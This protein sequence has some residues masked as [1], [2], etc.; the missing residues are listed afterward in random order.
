MNNPCLKRQELVQ[1]WEVRVWRVEGSTRGLIVIIS[2]FRSC[3]LFAFSQ[4]RRDG[5]LFFFIPLREPLRRQ[6]LRHQPGSIRS[7]NSSF[8]SAS[9]SIL[10]FL[11]V[12]LRRPRRVQTTSLA[13]G[14]NFQRLGAALFHID[15]A[16]CCGITVNES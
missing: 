16:D 6:T 1:P 9:L 2:M 4:T 8:F 11:S 7:F 5:S 15:A 14:I 3:L 13:N 10:T 12:P